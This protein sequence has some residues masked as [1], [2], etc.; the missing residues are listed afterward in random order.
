MK[1][2][3]AAALAAGL[4]ATV[5]TAPFAYMRRDGDAGLLYRHTPLVIRK[6]EGSDKEM[7][8]EASS[9]QPVQRWGD[10]EILEHTPQAVVLERLLKVG[11]LLVNHDPDQRAAKI[12]A[13]EVRDGKLIIRVI[14]GTSD[15]AVQYK[16]DVDDGLLRGASAGYRILELKIDEQTKTYTATRWE[17]YEVS[18]TPVPADFTVGTTR[19]GAHQN[20]WRSITT[21]T[22]SQPQ[23][24]TMKFS[25][26]LKKRGFDIDAL[27]PADLNALRAAFAAHGEAH[28]PAKDVAVYA[29]TL[30]PEADPAPAAAPTPAPTPA[31]APVAGQ[32]DGRGATSLNFRDLT[33]T[34]EQLNLRASDYADL[35]GDPAAAVRK[36]LADSAAQRS[37]NGGQPIAV[38]QVVADGMQ[39]RIDAAVDGFL[40]QSGIRR[41]DDEKDLGMRRMSPLGIVR[42]FLTGFD[43]RA[44][45]WDNDQLARFAARQLNDLQLRDANQIGAT[46]ANLLANVADKILI[47]GYKNAYQM[48]H[49]IWTRQ[50]LVND[51][52]TVQGNAVLTGLMK[53][54]LTKGAPA[55]EGQMVEQNYNAALGL[56]LTSFSFHYQDWRNDDLGELFDSVMGYGK[57]AAMTEDYQTYKLVMG[58]TWTNRITTTAAFWDDTN[59]KP[60]YTGLE[61]TVAAL[62]ARK[63]TVGDVA[64]PIG[65]QAK[66]LLVP[67]IKRARANIAS[68]AAAPGAAYANPVS[69]QGL[70]VV[71][72]PWLTNTELTGNDADDYYLAAG[73]MDTVRMLKDRLNPAPTIRAAD[74]GMTPDLAFFVMHAFRPAM[75]AQDGMQKGDW[76]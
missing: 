70:T 58:A 59:D 17:V 54:Q 2:R 63:V 72:V 21:P 55:E 40:A 45:N 36:M 46:F 25:A 60:I 5:A 49:S 48:T 73:N 20:A 15:A 71:P 37:A 29:R 14:F 74:P 11:T 38:S 43:V 23:G 51:F 28:D 44:Q 12:T 33:L 41:R 66:F 69:G 32:A 18:L 50:R 31:P 64:V 4:M 22:R 10:T 13:A 42:Q 7:E 39:K 6:V 1:N 16:K 47:E 9:T 56:F 3:A 27:L 30:T 52:K 68:G 26:W 62:N 67:D 76:A 8:I 19:D 35:A 65:A 75:A 34:A 24:S 61:K 53:E 57:I